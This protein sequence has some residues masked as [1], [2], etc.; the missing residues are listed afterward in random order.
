MV[1]WGKKNN[2]NRLLLLA[3]SRY[4]GIIMT[5]GTNSFPHNKHEKKTS[6]L[7]GTVF[8]VLQWPTSGMYYSSNIILH[9]EKNKWKV[10]ANTLIS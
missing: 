6:H 4:F 1:T 2:T 5:D 9:N 8:K 7:T 10:Q 3:A